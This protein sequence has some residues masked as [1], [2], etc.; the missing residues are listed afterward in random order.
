MKQTK[1]QY[2]DDMYKRPLA[3]IPWEIEAPPSELTE[4]IKTKKVE[5]GAA[6]DIGCG[7]GNYAQYLA[8]KGFTV[9]GIDFS[10]TAVAIARE[11][12]AR[13]QLPVVY[14]PL[15]KHHGFNRG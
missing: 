9:T 7:T 11:H 14:V 4:L 10:R 2:W 1:Q 3:D 12:A 6:L 13:L 15:T 8:K 5:P